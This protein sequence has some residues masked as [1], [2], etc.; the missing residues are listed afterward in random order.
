MSNTIELDGPHPQRVR[1]SDINLPTVYTPALGTN[2]AGYYD[3]NDDSGEIRGMAVIGPNQ[4]LV[5]TT[6]DV[7]LFSYAGL[8][9]VWNISNK[10][11]QDVG[12]LGSYT[13]IAKENSHYFFG[14]EGFYKV[15]SSITPERIG[16]DR[17]DNTFFNLFQLNLPWLS[18]S[19]AHPLYPEI[20]FIYQGRNDSFFKSALIYNWE[21]SVWTLRSVF[22]FSA[23]T[24][25]LL[26]SS[27]TM[28]QIATPGSTTLT[29]AQK[30][31]S[32]SLVL[33]S[34]DI[35]G[36]LFIHDGTDNLANGVPLIKSLRSGDL[37]YTDS[38]RSARLTRVFWG[39]SDVN[40]PT[41]QVTSVI[42]S[43]T[44]KQ[45]DYELVDQFVLDDD[46]RHDLRLVDKLVQL[47]LDTPATPSL[48]DITLQVQGAGQRA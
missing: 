27:R 9:T 46:S 37:A 12:C 21:K 15:T 26:S 36:H 1:W 24:E 45:D 16:E 34:G 30:A 10:V 48:T 7:Y 4:F 3:I 29:W 23:I 2:E 44:N 41:E 31:G 13:L 39:L 33:I 5:Y 38:A 43:K 35:N 19:F 8:P 28:D 17:V 18:Y 22:P 20:W 6:K 14:I 42:L 47:G 40:L 11:I 25:L 32:G